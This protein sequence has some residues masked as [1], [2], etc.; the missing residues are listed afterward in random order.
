M[1]N[2]TLIVY[3]SWSEDTDLVARQIQSVTGGTLLRLIP[4]LPYPTDYYKCVEQAKLEL[5]EK[6]TPAL[7]PFSLDLQQYDTV[8]LGSPI[9]CGTFASAIRTFLSEYDLSGKTVLP[10]CCHGGGGQRNF[11]NDLRGLLDG[12]NIKETLVL[13]G[14]GGSSGKKEISSWVRRNFPIAEKTGK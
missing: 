5:K 6:A 8:F 7:Q 14:S 13:F 2:N 1:N 12:S 4:Q 10:F 9:W 11:T 3:Y